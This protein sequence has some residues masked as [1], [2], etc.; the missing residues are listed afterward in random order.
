[1]QSNKMLV[2]RDEMDRL[3]LM[4]VDLDKY[5]TETIPDLHQQA[6]LLRQALREYGCHKPS[7]RLTQQSVASCTCG[8]EAAIENS[9]L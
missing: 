4:R 6:V 7:C 2:G 5:E 1:M 8:L 9:R 3:I